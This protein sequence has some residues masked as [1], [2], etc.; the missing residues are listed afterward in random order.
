[1]LKTILYV[2]AVIGLLISPVHAQAAQKDCERMTGQ[3]VMAPMAI[4]MASDR[5]ACCDHGMKD[6][7]T[8]DAAC[9]NNC[10]AMC[11]TNVACGTET[12]SLLPVLAVEQV[13][14]NDAAPSLLTQQPGLVIP[15]PKSIT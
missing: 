8:K 14:F 10:I 2:F 1:M 11:G 4:P 3:I 6:K 12:L 7:S 9:F 13:S 15:P 5:M